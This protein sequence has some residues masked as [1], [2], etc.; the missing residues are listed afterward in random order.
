VLTIVM[1]HYV[2]DAERTAFP[3][4]HARGIAD[5][6]GQLDYVERNYEPVSLAAVRDAYDGARE[7]PRRACLLTFDDGLADHRDAVLPA[8]ARRGLPGCFSPSAAA[9][10]ER[11]VLDVQKSQF[12]RAAEP[13]HTRLLEEIFAAL[14]PLAGERPELTPEALRR[15]T[16]PD[17]FDDPD[18]T[19]LKH[20][21]QHALPDAVRRP[22]LDRLFREVVTDDERGFAEELYLSLADVQTLVA[23]GLEL[24]GHGVA[25]R[26][27]GLLDRAAQQEEI[28][29]TRSFLALVAGRE[30]ERWA[31]CYPSGSCNAI[32]VE[33]CRSA[34]CV[35]GM[36]DQPG[37]A[38]PGDDPLLLPRLDTNDLP[39]A[40][41]AELSDWTRSRP[42]E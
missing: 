14:E 23:E 35:L 1:Y 5:F 10:L 20:L 12:V 31:M 21:L 7:L 34:G 30:P 26:H 42:P 41:D 37:L 17:R 28:D 16:P 18:S 22:V 29:G 11:R 32:T 6:E 15:A 3:G 4:I 38:S 39:V 27:L 36:T 13:D 40:G 2:R 25:H 33:L 8:L 9:A 24:A 19:L